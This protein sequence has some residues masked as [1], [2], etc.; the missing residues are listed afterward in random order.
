[1]HGEHKSVLNAHNRKVTT[2]EIRENIKLC[3]CNVKED[4]PLKGN[5]LV[6]NSL[7]EGTVTSKLPRHK[8]KVYTGVCE[9]IFKSR[10]GNHKTSFNLRKYGTS[11]EITKKVWK[12]NDQRGEPMFTWR[13]IKHYPAYNPISKWCTLCLSE[14]LHIAEYG[15]NLLNKRED[16]ISKC[17]HHNKFMLL[18]LLLL[19]LL[20]SLY[21]VKP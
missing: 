20:L 14:K 2:T 10:Y 15:D 9:P 16:I 17:R 7:Y 8:A 21:V 4:C 1:M 11:R 5:F 18:N 19:L 13:I 3:N 12:I 6:V